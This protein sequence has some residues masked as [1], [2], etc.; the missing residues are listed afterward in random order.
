MKLKDMKISKK[1]AA[2]FL[3]I[4]IIATIIGAVGIGGLF[5][6]DAADTKLYEKQTLP[7]N[8]MFSVIENIYK[9]DADL[10]I[11]IGNAGN[12]ELIKSF[13]EDFN[14][15]TEAYAQSYENY[16]SSI[17]TASSKALFEEADEIVNN[18]FIPAAKKIFE[19]AKQGKASEANKAGEAM[20]ESYNKMLGN[21]H[22]C[23]AN[24][25]KNA[26][27][28][29]DSNDRLFTVLS[30]VLSSVVVLGLL[31][32]ILLARYI[33]RIISKPINQMVDAANEIA[34]GNTDI[35]VE[36]ESRDET[37]MLAEAFGRMIAGIKEQV[38]VVLALA[39]GDLSIEV[40]PRSEKDTMGIALKG[41]VEQLNNMFSEIN[42]AAEQVSLGAQQVSGGA[43]SLS[44][45]STEQ[46]SSIEE[47]SASIMQIS[48]KINGNAKNVSL[49]AQYANDA[50]EEVARGMEQMRSMLS[51]MSEIDNSSNEISKIIKV[52][53]DIAF[54]TNILALNAAVEAARA[55]AAGKGF[56]V[57]ADE[58]RNLASKSADA[59]KQTTSLI[60]NSIQIVR[61]GS[62][63][64][65]KT[66]SSLSEI[67]E[68]TTLVSKAMEDISKASAEQA[69]AIEQ[70]NR[71]IEQISAVVQTNSATAEESAASSEE[72]SS[73]ANILKEQIST[74]KLKNYENETASPQINLDYDYSSIKKPDMEFQFD[75]Y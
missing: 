44:Q 68:K 32:S 39:R 9:M 12:E 29:S 25:F 65:E 43:Q 54:Q 58:V 63:I 7:L 14:K 1:L 48:S 15:L 10:R 30:I 2:G 28:T 13:E 53:D 45:G 49:A 64:A 59:A 11:A 6:M 21:F 67:E 5:A 20:G 73:Q 17:V 37:G 74:F 36:V 66:A 16:K 47:L 55:G 69:E 18:T 4:S 35:A 42:R 19:L 22:Q 40:T 26:K 23:L 57:V 8:D 61:N 34:L 50:G 46:A 24:R 51:A 33:S 27:A 60:E 38:S 71:G 3:V 56:A 72:L 31:T 62:Q 75:K 70:I 52:I 41:T